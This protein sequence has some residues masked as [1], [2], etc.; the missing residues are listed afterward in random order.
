MFHT[1]RFQTKDYEPYSGSLCIVGLKCRKSYLKDGDA[2]NPT[3]QKGKNCISKKRV[4]GSFHVGGNLQGLRK[5]SSS[6]C[7]ITMP[8]HGREGSM[9]ALVFATEQDPVVFASN[10]LDVIS[11]WSRASPF[12]RSTPSVMKIRPVEALSYIVDARSWV[13]TSIGTEE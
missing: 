7:A 9:I 1:R 10:A 2:H 3:R 6:G 13:N 11:P 8:G 12:R 5:A 4:S